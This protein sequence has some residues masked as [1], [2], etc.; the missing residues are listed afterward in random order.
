M[1]LSIGQMLA[2]HAR[3]AAEETETPVVKTALSVTCVVLDAALVAQNV[4]RFAQNLRVAQSDLTQVTGSLS[5]R[6][7]ERQSQR[8]A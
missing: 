2:A 4:S 7:R 3:N 6:V 5:D 1:L 8:V